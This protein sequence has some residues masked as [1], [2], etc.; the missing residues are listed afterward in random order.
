MSGIIL[1]NP[2]YDTNVAAALRACSCFGVHDLQYTGKRFSQGGKARIPREMR[3]RCYKDVEMK[4]SLR[5]FDNIGDAI[6]VAI[7]VVENAENLATFE[8]PENAV[9]VFG[10]ENGSI[11]GVLLRHC[12]HFV[13]IPSRHCLNL[14]G[15][16]YV[17]LYD[18]AAKR[19]D[20]LVAL[21][22]F[23]RDPIIVKDRQATP[24]P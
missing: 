14:A 4:Y 13:M 9:Y 15:A 17:T 10:P 3:K 1:V 2:K 5:P 19:G 12:H 11:P 8:H 22:D 7:E 24:C 23:N 21:A 18:R 20:G 16:V 6:P